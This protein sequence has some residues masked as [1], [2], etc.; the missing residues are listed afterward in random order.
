MRR[1]RAEFSAVLIVLLV[2]SPAMGAL[3]AFALHDHC[4]T[5]HHEC[6]RVAHLAQCC[7]R[8]SGNASQPSGL[9][10]EHR[11]L[12]SQNA[13]PVP[14]TGSTAVMPQMVGPTV[15][16]PAHSPPPDLPILLVNLRI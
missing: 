9:P 5:L 16:Q 14:W 4:V 6:G 10:E 12:S 2:S 1:L 11:A 7:C 3:Q 8:E 15:V 13:T